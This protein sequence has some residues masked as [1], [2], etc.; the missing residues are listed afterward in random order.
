MLLC[1]AQRRRTPRVRYCT[2]NVNGSVHTELMITIDA[3]RRGLGC[4]ALL[5]GLA[6]T[7]SAQPQVADFRVAVRAFEA[8]D[9]QAR[10]DR[11][12]DMRRGLEIGLPPLIVTDRARDIGRA[13]RLLARR[14]RLTRHPA[15]GALFTPPIATE[16]RRALELVLTT[17]SVA[18][19]MDENPGSFEYRINGDYPKYR[20]LASMPG[21]ALAI[22]PALPAD[23]HYRFVG[24]FLILHDTRAN[25]ILDRM[26]VAFREPSRTLR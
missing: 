15:E 21:T 10:L 16:I 19:I 26:A 12:I 3:A 18:T 5:I 6:G 13:E 25:I 8:G 22:L 20:K 2:A 4:T 7:A 9:F 24:D 1:I 14:V 23:I 11:Y 17:S